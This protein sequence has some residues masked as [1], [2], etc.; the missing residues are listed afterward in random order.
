MPNVRKTDKKLNVKKLGCKKW[1][2]GWQYRLQFKYSKDDLTS[3]L[4]S[5][6]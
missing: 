2:F 1:Y 5:N 3:N 6:K 4:T